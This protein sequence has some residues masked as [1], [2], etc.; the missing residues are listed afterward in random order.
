MHNVID[1][2]EIE[3]IREKFNETELH[4]EILH[5][6]R[7]VAALEKD[8]IG[9]KSHLASLKHIRFINSNV[10][11]KVSKKRVD[12][13]EFCDYDLRYTKDLPRNMDNVK[14]VAIAG[15]GY[16]AILDDDCDG[17]NGGNYILSNGLPPSRIKTLLDELRDQKHNDNDIDNGNDNDNGNCDG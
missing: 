5:Y 15:G 1:D 6:E 14:H 17:D 4:E 7:Q 10:H 11:Q 8:L 13:G 3:T 12:R 9:K 2:A 16:A